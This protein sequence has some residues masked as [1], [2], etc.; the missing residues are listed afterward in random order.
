MGTMNE[1]SCWALLLAQL[2]SEAGWVHGQN[3]CRLLGWQ[4]SEGTLPLNVAGERLVR[5]AGNCNIAEMRD[6]LFAHKADPNYRRSVLGSLGA[7]HESAGCLP[8]DRF[9]EVLDLI[10][11]AGGDIDIVDA[12]GRT[13]MHIVLDTQC[14]P[15]QDRD[16]KVALL[17][18]RGA[19]PGKLMYRPLI[20]PLGI[21]SELEWRDLGGTPLIY[22]TRGRRNGEGYSI[23]SDVSFKTLL[24]M[25]V[26][27]DHLEECIMDMGQCGSDL[28][29]PACKIIKLGFGNDLQM[30]SGKT[31]EGKKIT[32][33]WDKLQIRHQLF[34][35]GF[36]DQDE[37]VRRAKLI[38]DHVLI[39]LIDMLAIPEDELALPDG[40]HKLRAKCK[41]LC[42]YLLDQGVGAYCMP[43]L[44]ATAR[45]ANDACEAMYNAL[46]EGVSGLTSLT[47]DATVKY[48]DIC[49]HPT[50]QLDWLRPGEEN[51]IT[52][53][54]H[55][56]RCGA[57]KNMSELCTYVSS[58]CGTYA[59]TYYERG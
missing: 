9:A 21:K 25:M 35:A 11:E 5:A 39:P 44:R 48:T 32:V 54:H 2:S 7:L 6:Y 55:L 18:D 57:I 31:S 23:E 8:A 33:K 50:D 16:D 19:H 37:A 56:L 43:E 22:G 41:D 13:P 15:C 14:P 58:C 38:S 46:Y 12:Q 3:M 30:F 45:R 52:A 36:S 20:L 40:G 47:P 53:V 28:I 51:T 4:E 29:Q 34:I 24:S 10:L 1:T 49:R 26:P 59:A 27:W 17:L 42:I